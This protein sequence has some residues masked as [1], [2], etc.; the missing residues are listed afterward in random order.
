MELR[1]PFYG[2]LIGRFTALSGEIRRL[3]AVAF[4]IYRR[5]SPS[6]EI[7]STVFLT[8][9]SGWPD[10]YSSYFRNLQVQET[11]EWEWGA[12]ALL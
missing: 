5:Q 2:I 1:I 9:S 11:I 10:K 4:G 3:E 8:V 6:S 7:F 12:K